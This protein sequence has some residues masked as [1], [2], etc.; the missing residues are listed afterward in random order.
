MVIAQVR[1]SRTRSVF[2]KKLW[3]NRKAVTRTPGVPH[4]VLIQGVLPERKPRHSKTRAIEDA[5]PH[6]TQDIL[7][8]HFGESGIREPTRTRGK[9]LCALVATEGAK[10]RANT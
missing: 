3:R 5:N 9:A 1:V 4:V 2:E 6:S 8:A 10:D 7:G